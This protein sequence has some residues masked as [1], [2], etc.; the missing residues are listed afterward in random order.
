M[1]PDYDGDYSC[2]YCGEVVY[3]GEPATAAADWDAL[4]SRARRT[5]TGQSDAP[6]AA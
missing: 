3:A 1:C 4:L 5:L 2:M 6:T